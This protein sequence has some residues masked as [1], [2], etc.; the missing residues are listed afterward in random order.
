MIVSELSFFFQPRWK[1]PCVFKCKKFCGFWGPFCN[2]FT[3]QNWL[4]NWC[5]AMVIC[6]NCWCGECRNS[7]LR[8]LHLKDA[9][10]Y[11]RSI[12]QALELPEL[13]L[14][15]LFV[16]CCFWL[17]KIFLYCCYVLYTRSNMTPWHFM[18]LSCI[19]SVK[20]QCV[21]KLR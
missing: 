5:K 18:L 15:C 8:N 21:V 17:D 6:Q 9:N 10:L 12:L 3:S 20:W 19:L 1:V 16:L 14:W 2:R 11:I 7:L 13:K 4:A